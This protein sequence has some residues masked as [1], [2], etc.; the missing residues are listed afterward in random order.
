VDSLLTLAWT[1][2]RALGAPDEGS[3]TF[4]TPALQDARDWILVEPP[5]RVLNVRVLH[6][7]DGLSDHAPVLA[8]VARS[9][10]AM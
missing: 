6:E 9:A 5:L 10:P 2:P 4:P 8:E 3:F 7:A 1:S